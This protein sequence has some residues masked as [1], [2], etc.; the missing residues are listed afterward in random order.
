MKRFHPP[1][2]DRAIPIAVACVVF[3]F[4]CAVVLN[5]LEAS[6][7][8]EMA[9]SLDVEG[10]TLSESMTNAEQGVYIL[11]SMVARLKAEHGSPLGWSL[12]DLPVMPT[13][14]FDNRKNR[15]DSVAYSTL[16]LVNFFTGELA[17]YGNSNDI[18]KYLDEAR[19]PYLALRGE[20]G[21][22]FV[23]DEIYHDKA[24][25]L[26]ETYERN[27]MEDNSGVKGKDP[28]LK[29]LFNMKTDEIYSLIELLNGNTLLDHARTAVSGEIGYLSQDDTFYKAKGTMLVVR[30]VFNA[31]VIAR[32]DIM[33]RGGRA[34]IEECKEYLDEIAMYDPLLI[35]DMF[36]HRARMYRLIDLVSQR[37]YDIQKA[38]DK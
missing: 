20:W 4:A 1:K 2:I 5:F 7:R 25:A 13:S 37:L 27:L 22:L 19:N 3:F 12:N 14:W 28:K 29:S 32:P 18:N 21:C 6:D 36:G 15:Q 9:W 33:L 8:P 23:S 35:W 30:D 10:V 24:L 11:E 31:L 17:R 38:M 34:N 26:I 16:N